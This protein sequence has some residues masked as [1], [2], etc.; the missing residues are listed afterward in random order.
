MVIHEDAKEVVAWSN[1]LHATGAR[2]V[3]G[4]YAGISVGAIYLYAI[5]GS[6]LKKISSES[7]SLGILILFD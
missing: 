3:A 1:C 6:L 4:V 7:M 2:L 5:L